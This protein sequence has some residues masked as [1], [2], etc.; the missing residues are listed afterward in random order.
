MTGK[1][2][3]KKIKLKYISCKKKFFIFLQLICPSQWKRTWTKV[4]RE[5]IA[6]F[7]L[8]NYGRMNT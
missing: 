5:V 1:S 4:K 2:Q 7:N 8:M 3:L 6:N